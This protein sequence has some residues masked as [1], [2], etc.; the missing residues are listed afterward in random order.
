MISETIKLTKHRLLNGARSK[1]VIL[2]SIFPDSPSA[3]PILSHSH[4]SNKT[5]FDCQH[6]KSSISTHTYLSPKTSFFESTSHTSI[7]WP[8]VLLL[9]WL[10]SWDLLPQR[11]PAQWFD[12]TLVLNVPSLLSSSFNSYQD[13]F[14]C[15]TIQYISSSSSSYTCRRNSMGERTTR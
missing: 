15:I 8:L 13:S 3:L 10:P 2:S 6:S 14:N 9:R 5:S 7:Q 4:Q 1:I 12:P 11:L